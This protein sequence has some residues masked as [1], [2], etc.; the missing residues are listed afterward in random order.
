MILSSERHLPFGIFAFRR[1]Q[2]IWLFFC[3]Y[4]WRRPMKKSISNAIDVCNGNYTKVPAYELVDSTKNILTLFGVKERVEDLLNRV[5]QR[6]VFGMI[7]N[8]KYDEK[9]R[10]TA[11]ELSFV[12]DGK[13]EN[14]YVNAYVYDC[15]HP[16]KSKMD[17]IFLKLEGDEIH[18]IF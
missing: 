16:E 2:I 5:G 15:L 7:G 17:Q 8:V 1:F 4:D 12:V 3:S 18:R 11:Q 9:G 14:G 6:K 10:T 13:S